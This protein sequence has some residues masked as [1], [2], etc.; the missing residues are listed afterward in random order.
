MMCVLPTI[1]SVPAVVT[2]WTSIPTVISGKIAGKVVLIAYTLYLCVTDPVQVLPCWSL[3]G[4]DGDQL[5]Q[6]L[7]LWSVWGGVV[8][9]TC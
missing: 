1:A 8:V 2:G 3:C 4:L 9:L 5:L 6:D 7:Y